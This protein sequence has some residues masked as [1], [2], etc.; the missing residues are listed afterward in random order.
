MNVSLPFIR[1]PVATILL[2]LGLL[3][4][5]GVAYRFLGV[6]SLPSVD[7]P[8]IVVIAARPGADPETMAASISA[9][10]ERRL[11]EIAGVSEITSF[12][13]VGAATIVVQFDISRP[14]DSA[15]HDVQAAI[16]SAVADLPSDLP[17]P[18]Y[19]RK[20]NPADSPVVSIALT[21]DTVST[22]QLYDAADSIL[23]QR[24]SQV[25]GVSQV[26]INGAEKPAVRV[27]LDPGALAAT[28]LAA[29]DVYNAIRAANVIQPN[30]SFSGP[31]RAEDIAVNGQ[32]SQASD[33]RPLILRATNGAILRLGDVASVID[34]VANTRLAAWDG[35]QP[36][37]LLNVTKVA[38]AN[39]IDTVDRVRAALPQLLEWMPH[40]INTTIIS[41]RTGTI[42]ASVRDVQTTL[43]ISIGLVLLVMLLFMRRTVPTVAAAITVPLS[44][45]GTLAG[46]WFLGYTLDNFSLIALTVSVGFVVDDAIVMIENVV[47][48]MEM[49]KTA[50][51]AAIEGSRQIGF[52]VVSISI[53]LVAVFIPLIFMGGV[54]GK[55][56]HEFAMT[57][58]MAILI[59]GAVSLS[60]TPMVCGHFMTSKGRA[61]PLRAPWRQIDQ[62]IE[63]LLAGMTRFYIITLDAALNM[64]WIML[65]LMAAT[66]GATVWLY[67]L[68]P[69][70]LMP[71]QDTGLV[72]GSTLAGP[73]VS[74]QAMSDLQRRVVDIV[75]A[76]PAVA[77]VGSTIGV[78]TGFSSLNRGSLTVQ[79]KPLDQRGVGS[80]AVIARLR[81]KLARL[82]GVETVMFS[83][84]D[85]RTGGRSGGSQ[86]QFV[87]LDQDLAE[88]RVWSQR[89]EDQLRTTPGLT[90]VTSDQDRAGPQQNV[91]IDRDAAARLGVSTSAIDNALNN[92]FS[93]RQISTIYTERN[94][95]RVVL[96][97]DPKFQTDAS[98]LDRVYVGATNGSQVRLAALAHF[99]P[100]Y[101]PLGVRHQGQFPAATISFNVPVGTAL[102][103]A[104]GIVEKAAADLRMPDTVHTEFAGNAK[105]L[106]QSLASQP[107]LIGAALISIYL[108]LG[109]LYESL[110]Q[111]L[112][113]LSTLPSAGL[114]ALLAILVTGGELTIISIIGIILLMG[115]VKKNGIMLVD[116]AL[117]AERE[118]GM[119]PEAAIRAACLER[120]RPIMM[121][122]LAALLGALPLA[123]GFGSGSELRT[124]LGVA[125]AG[126]LIV[127]QALTLYTTPV[128]YLALEKLAGGKR[129]AIARAAAE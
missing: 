99:V 21:S 26:Q 32:L 111:P 65:A 80:E 119:N 81:P 5:G 52:T 69:K 42:R 34:G 118:H 56:F 121:T 73:D 68:V 96:E 89:L 4:A 3:L 57:I 87:L 105:L 59:S 108:V 79:L 75:L 126:G 53:S 7:I 113:I 48:H 35:K 91:E 93:Q 27:R 124:P 86:F 97:V 104:S 22:A 83:A 76:D 67:M 117:E 50:M 114:G 107:L 92:A 25:D 37:I 103:V 58:T 102:G 43:L 71:T 10:L 51:Q 82:T 45:A 20:F 9:P 88:L 98:M 116:F 70:G 1:R 100:G 123:F 24:L 46:M 12:S 110:I 95:Y 49:G 47:R 54:L 61:R 29:Q 128:V 101:A 127:S 39:V 62:A 19:F 72:M 122:T 6:A 40:G 63:R 13:A 31:D 11:G 106:Q 129:R 64:R 30:G 78:S 85:L 2:A 23:G 109:V 14:I 28:G 33:Y 15:A 44:L 8:T 60:L 90:D 125:I 41:D 74:F 112:T 17:N 84:Q 16:N 94:Q 115:I 66:I 120:F 55:L 38:G 36:A 18:P 77:S